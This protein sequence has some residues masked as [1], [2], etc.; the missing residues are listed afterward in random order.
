M[1]GTRGR[2]YIKHPH[3]FKV[4]CHSRM[5]SHGNW[6]RIGSVCFSS[7]VY[8][9]PC[10]LVC[11][12]GARS[13]GLTSTR[14]T[15]QW[16]HVPTE[17]VGLPEPGLRLEQGRRSGGRAERGAASWRRGLLGKGLSPV[18]S[19]VLAA[20]LQYAAD[21]QDKHWLTEQQHMRAIG[22]KMVSTAGRRAR[23]RAS[24]GGGAVGQAAV[25]GG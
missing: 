19:S 8:F 3:L 24:T 11:Y 12:L 6:E 23:R 9:L 17:V 5:V 15:S 21:Q 18:L 7:L 4:R 16:C 20:L 25:A 10:A 1:G 14:N 22:G 2:L 13:Q